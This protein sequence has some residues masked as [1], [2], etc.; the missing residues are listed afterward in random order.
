MSNIDGLI[1]QINSPEDADNALL[2]TEAVETLLNRADK[3]GE[4]AS[5]FALKEAELLVYIAKNG[6]EG[7][8]RREII[9]W[10]RKKSDAEIKLMLAECATGRRLSSI[11]AE[12]S[13]RANAEA[14][15]DSQI[16]E[17]KRINREMLREY[18]ETGK[19][20]MTRDEFYSRWSR[21]EMPDN[22]TVNAYA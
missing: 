2:E 5:M 15:A 8:K 6:Y 1:A 17:L 19:T 18:Q 14:V 20:K 13:R 11:K 7:K 16:K 21:K 10:I 9:A 12:E 4:Y 22:E 3:Y